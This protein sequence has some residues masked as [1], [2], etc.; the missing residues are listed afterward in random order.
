MLEPCPIARKVRADIGEP[1][2]DGPGLCP[3]LGGKDEP[4][5]KE[6]T[7]AICELFEIIVEKLPSFSAELAE[8]FGFG[9][10]CC[11]KAQAGIDGGPLFD[12]AA[13]PPDKKRALAFQIMRAKVLETEGGPEWIAKQN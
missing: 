5:E 12:I 1:L 6:G 13:L 3:F 9:A 2:A 10:G 4:T 11:L 8:M 7:T